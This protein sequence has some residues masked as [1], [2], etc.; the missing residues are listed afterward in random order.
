LQ[1]LQF[2]MLLQQIIAVA[3]HLRVLLYLRNIVTDFNFSSLCTKKRR[4][5]HAH[6]STVSVALK[7]TRTE[8]SI[9]LGLLAHS[10]TVLAAMAMESTWILYLLTVGPDRP[11][12]FLLHLIDTLPILTP[13]LVAAASLA[14][15]SECRARVRQMFTRVR[16]M[17]TN[18]RIVT[19]NASV[20]TIER[21]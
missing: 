12:T 2:Y 4:R 21:D 18:P 13:G 6:S 15:I 11:H 20:A 3:L 16:R 7:N 14:C 10:L 1:V 19:I 5:T 8:Y 9:S 17:R